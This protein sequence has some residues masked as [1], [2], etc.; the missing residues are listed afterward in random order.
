MAGAGLMAWFTVL[1]AIVH[2]IPDR[3]GAIFFWLANTTLSLVLLSFGTYCAVV[4][5][6]YLLL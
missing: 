1:I 2:F 5:S 4:L 3:V 6:R